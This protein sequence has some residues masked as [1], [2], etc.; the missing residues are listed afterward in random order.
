[1]EQ[2]RFKPS[3]AARILGVHPWTMRRWIREGKVPA[4]RSETN[5]LYISRNW[6]DAQTSGKTGDGII[7]CAIYARESSSENKAALRSQTEGLKRY[8]QAK[9]YQIIHVVT[10]IGSGINDERPK[11]HRLLKLPDFDILLVEHK[12]RLSRLGF[13]WF[14]TLCPF[15]IEVVNLAENKI[16][17]LMEDLVAII[18]SFCARLYGQRRGRRKTEA[19]IQVLKEA[20]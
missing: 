16:N 10:E 9:G 17:D 4:F 13:R 3:E 8:A 20:K 12:D 14:E 7:R 11:L 2:Q 6:I 19:A 5:R 15:K 1:M 18:T